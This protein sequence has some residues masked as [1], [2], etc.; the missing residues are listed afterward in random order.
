MI[1]GSKG[2]GAEVIVGTLPPSR[3]GGDHAVATSLLTQHN[4]R[5]RQVAASE[6]ATLV[7]LY[8]PML[9]LVN[10]YI[11]VDG[12]HP[13]EEGCAGMAELFAQAIREISRSAR[14]LPA[15]A[16]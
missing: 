14:R 6:G 13:N 8:G 1:R 2:R 16:D 9:G 3:P 7:D 11:G 5:L 10:V 15:F 4:E 12:L